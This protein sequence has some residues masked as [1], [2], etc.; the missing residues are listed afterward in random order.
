MSQVTPETLQEYLR[1]HWLNRHAP[2]VR[3]LRA[4]SAGWE[5]DVYAFD[6]EHG[7]AEGR[8]VEPLVLRVY[9]GTVARRKAEREFRGMSQLMR[10]GYPV[11]AVHLLE[12]DASPFGQPFMVMERIDGG[13]LW[14]GGDPPSDVEIARMVALFCGLQVRLHALDWR[15]FVPDP[16]AIEAGGPYA[17][18]D[19]ELRSQEVWI[20]RIGGAGY[21]RVIE[22][23]LARREGV[24]CRRPAVVHLDFHPMNILVRPDGSAVVIDWTN[25]HVSDARLDLAWTLMLTGSAMGMEWRDRIL[26]E[27]ER[28]A[29]A[30]V[31]GIAYF[32]ALA[33]MRRLL[34]VAVSVHLGPAELG[35]RGD[36]VAAM[37]RQAPSIRA[38][39]HLLRR[40]TDTVVPEVE[41][42][43]ATIEA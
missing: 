16:S 28:Q 5:S 43:L 13:M 20:A 36:A 21:G 6:L 7:P 39:Y 33:C 41:D 8:R 27:Y 23:L 31:D 2:V 40:R 1:T 37:R 11:P 4:M 35:M 29:G 22:W 24:P 17:L 25:I 18:L 9:P 38:V 30:P 32:E 14:A 3:D 26:E 12:C 19:T 15:P 10:A 42:L 34:S